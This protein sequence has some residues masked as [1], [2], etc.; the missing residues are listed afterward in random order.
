MDHHHENKDKEKMN[1]NRMQTVTTV[2]STVCVPVR[3]AVHFVCLY[4]RPIES[5]DL[6]V[7]PIE[8]SAVVVQR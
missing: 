2:I 1:R 5:S 4:G 7:Q 8:S 3:P 6:V